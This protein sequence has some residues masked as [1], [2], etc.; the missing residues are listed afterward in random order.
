MVRVKES[1]MH[2]VTALSGSGPAYGFYLAEAL[3]EAGRNSKLN[4]ALSE[5]LVHQ[6]MYGLGVDVGAIEGTRGDTE[7]KT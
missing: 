4:A 3:I 1:Q 7:K 6:T 2:A 5:T